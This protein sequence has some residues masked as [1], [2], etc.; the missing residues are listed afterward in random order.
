MQCHVVLE[1]MSPHNTNGEVGVAADRHPARKLRRILEL[2]VVATRAGNA[3]IDQ[4][5]VNGGNIVVVIRRID[6]ACNVVTQRV[7]VI[8]DT[9]TDSK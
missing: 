9:E 2:R 6:I 7:G 8:V 3:S 1:Q 4:L 5:V